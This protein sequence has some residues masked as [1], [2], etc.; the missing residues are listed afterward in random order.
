MFRVIF[1]LIILICFVS[2]K[3]YSDEIELNKIHQ[4]Y[5]MTYDAQSNE[6]RIYAYLN[7]N[8]ID[9]KSILL[10]EGST[11]KVNGVNMTKSGNYYYTIFNGIIDSAQIIFHDNRG[12]NFSNTIYCV[13]SISNDNTNILSK[14]INSTWY[15][16]GSPIQSGETVE[17]HL[18]M[19]NNSSLN[20]SINSSIIGMNHINIPF[21]E[22]NDLIVGIA[23]AQTRRYKFNY[24]GDW[25]LAGGRTKSQYF[26]QNSEINIVE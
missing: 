16:G 25:T 21:T 19:K 26:S 13:N 3:K 23:I 10:S 6:T 12:D 1:F 14:S 2:C 17:L 4:Y 5:S 11:L 24:N 7:E 9:G 18:K 15:F 20:S 22:L 8:H